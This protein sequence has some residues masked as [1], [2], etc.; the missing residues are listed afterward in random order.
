M[1]IL[2]K[3]IIE[4]MFFYDYVMEQAGQA[5][6]R[7]LFLK[8]IFSNKNNEFTFGRTKNTFRG[9]TRTRYGL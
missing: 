1:N 3:H 5:F 2:R 9:F 8:N 6:H 4:F 7:I